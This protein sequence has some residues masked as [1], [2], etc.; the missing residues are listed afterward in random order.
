MET[1]FIS[2]AP[3]FPNG[4]RNLIS[5]NGEKSLPNWICQCVFSHLRSIADKVVPRADF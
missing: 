2:L 4:H 3:A 1:L 5:F